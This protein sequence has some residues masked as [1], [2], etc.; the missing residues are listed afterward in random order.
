MEVHC[1]GVLTGLSRIRLCCCFRTIPRHLVTPCNG[2]ISCCGLEWLV[3]KGC[4]AVSLLK[5]FMLMK[6]GPYRMSGGIHMLGEVF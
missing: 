2:T 6:P 5:H 4:A 1:K 3:L